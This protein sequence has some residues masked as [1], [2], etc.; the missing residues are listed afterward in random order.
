M[1]LGDYEHTY[2]VALEVTVR[3]KTA[4]PD[5]V[6]MEDIEQYHGSDGVGIETLRVSYGG[7]KDLLPHEVR[8]AIGGKDD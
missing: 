3:S 5:Y 1:S 6:R 2:Y 4:E 8:K 7:Y